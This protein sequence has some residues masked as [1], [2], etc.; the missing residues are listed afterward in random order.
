MM[1]VFS[2]ILNLVNPVEILNFYNFYLFPVRYIARRSRPNIP[3]A[4]RL[5]LRGYSGGMSCSCAALNRP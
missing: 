5:E 3:V 2:F 4:I 1:L